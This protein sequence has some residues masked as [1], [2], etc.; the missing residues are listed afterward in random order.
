MLQSREALVDYM[1][2]LG[3]HHLFAWGHHYGPEPWCSVPGARPDW[4]PSYYHKADRD[5]IGFDRSSRGSNATAQ[6]PDALARQ[7]DDPRT[8]PEQYLLWFHHVPWTHRMRSGRTLWDELCLHYDRGVQ[9]VRL[10]QKYWDKV[11]KY[12]DEQRFKEVQSALKTQARDAV[13]WKDAC[14]LYFRQYSGLPFPDEIE[15]P[16]H[17]LDELKKVHLPIT[18]FECPAKELLN[19]YR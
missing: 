6:Y 11:E 3:L 15:R 10:F 9:Q 16:I 12:I 14:L 2:P 8:C 4:L 7:Y 17:E 18:N 19:K 1:M 13:W 5:G